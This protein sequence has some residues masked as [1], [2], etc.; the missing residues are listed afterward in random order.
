MS[1][2]AAATTLAKFRR[3]NQ[4]T[5]INQKVIVDEGQ[6]VVANDVLADGRPRTTASWHWARTSWSPSCRGRLQ[7]R[8]RHHPLRAVGARR[9]ADLD[10][11]RGARG[12][13]PGHPSSGPRRSPGTSPTCPRRSWPT[14]TS[15]HH[16]HRGRSR[17]R[18]RAR[19]QGH[20]KGETEQTP[21]ERLLRAIFGEKARE[22]RDTSLKVPHGESGKV[23]DVRVFSREDSHELP[24]GSTN[25]SVS[26]SL[27]SARSLKATSWPDGTATRG[28]SPRS[29][30]WRTC[31]SF[32]TAPTSTSS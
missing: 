10:P 6:R 17:P 15:G 3:S 27:R 11:H 21:E 14:S 1:S 29:C 26:M 20:A 7:L 5:S 32:P 22:V 9:R 13:R 31:R 23:I 28:S 30:P 16:P 24:P 2:A 18:R 8:G 12:R 25:S 4:N 19:G